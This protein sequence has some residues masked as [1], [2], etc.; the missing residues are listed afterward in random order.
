MHSLGAVGSWQN[1]GTAVDDTEN[2][3]MQQMLSMQHKSC[4]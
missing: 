3:N 2:K 1:M 4:I